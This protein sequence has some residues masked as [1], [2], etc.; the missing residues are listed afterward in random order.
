MADISLA[1]PKREILEIEIVGTAPLITHAW[2]QKAKEM[3]LAAQQGKKIAKEPKNPKADFEASRYR[4]ADLS[5]DGFPTM[6]FKQSTVSGGGRLFGKAVKMTEL[7]QHLLFLADGP[8]TDGLQLTRIISDEPEMREDL[9]RLNGTT[10]DLRYRAVY[11][12]WSA[13]LRIQF[14]PSVID[15]ESVL[16][17][18]DAGGA[19]GIG[20]WRPE[21]DGSFGTYEVLGY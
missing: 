19:N 10:A 8:G 4:F 12:N 13:V 6:G 2:S 3:M 16:A 17:L 11:E 7:R 21:R 1:R 5:G 14:V 15:K 20:E 18:V 9:V